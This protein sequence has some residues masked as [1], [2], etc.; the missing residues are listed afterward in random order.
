MNHELLIPRMLGEF[1]ITPL[2]IGTSRL[3]AFWQKHSVK[4][5]EEALNRALD[6]GVGLIDTADVYARGIS[7]RIV[8]RAVAHRSDVAVMTKVGLLKTPRGIWNARKYSDSVGLQG[9]KAAAVA[10]TCYAPGYIERA[11][12]DC[13]RRQKTDNLDIL[14]LH[15]PS[16]KVFAQTDVVETLNSMQNRGMIRAWG[17]SVRHQEATLAAL[18]AEGLTWLQIPINLGNTSIADTLVDHPARE[19]VNVVG[20]AVLGDGSLLP[21]ITRAGLS[22]PRAVATLVEGAYQHP[23]I[24]A[25]LLGMSRLTHVSENLAAIERGIGSIDITTVKHILES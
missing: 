22:R 23:A 24:D 3:G 18:D 2:G 4:E 12:W 10:D 20:I 8:G 5:G 25:V 6:L 11:A 13:I 21:Q 17:A 1:K 19:N 14:L 7:E 16:A 9:M 15:E